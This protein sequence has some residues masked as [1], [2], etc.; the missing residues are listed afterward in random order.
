MAFTPWLRVLGGLLAVKASASTT[1]LTMTKV[2]G[3]ESLSEDPFEIVVVKPST[4][5]SYASVFG[6]YIFVR[7]LH[8][9]C[10][11]YVL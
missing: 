1:R 9:L 8:F 10:F 7:S 3:Y 11:Q 2:G 6:G 4:N 5:V